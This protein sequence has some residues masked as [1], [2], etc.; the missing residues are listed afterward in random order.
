MPSEHPL[1]SNRVEIEHWA[2]LDPVEAERL[3]QVWTPYPIARFM[4]AWL[5]PI[6]GTILDPAVG[7]GVFLRALCDPVRPTTAQKLVGADLDEAMVESVR[8]FA[9][10]LPTPI[11]T[12]VGD[13]LEACRQGP[14]DGLI[15]N[16]PYIRHHDVPDEERLLAELDAETGLRF[17][18]LMNLYGIFVLRSALALAP[19]G[20]AAILVPSEWLNANFGR[21]L[22]RFLLL[23]GLLRGIVAFHFSSQ[24]FSGAMTTAGVLLLA[25]EPDEVPPPIAFLQV[26]SVDEL[27]ALE[28]AVA[29]A[30]SALSF[31]RLYEPSKLDP[32]AKWR[33]LFTSEEAAPTGFVRLGEFAR[34]TRGIAT[35]HNAFFLRRGSELDAAGVDRK[36]FT[37]CIGRSE[38]VP[39]GAFTSEDLSW[40]EGQ[41]LPIWLLSATPD[42]VASD[43]T[44]VAF[45][46]SPSGHKARES[47]LTQHR[48][49]WY[50]MES[51]PVAPIWIG[52]FSRGAVK[53]VRNQTEALTLACYHIVRPRQPEF[54]DL[55]SA[56]LRTDRFVRE[57]A[58]QRREYGSGLIKVEPK[59][60]ENVLIPDLRTFSKERRQ[61]ILRAEKRAE[62]LDAREQAAAHTQLEALFDS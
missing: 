62:S 57:L 21:A 46:D 16:P 59:D 30:E 51:R 25:N 61:A 4:A 17:S 6:T 3:G 10:A 52:T 32:D 7:S 29:Q 44:L 42:D 9:P 31:G 58:R 22:K 14:Y 1:F 37:P 12:L 49:V 41:D 45:L 39:A 48:K 34:A 53:V 5:H 24:V 15:L 55:I 11:E 23:R 56:Y 36:Y 2:G 40:L 20:R 60:L 54:A 35:G 18:R 33:T 50:V 47:Y 26:E 19:G 27:A 13:G 43:P 8:A 38:Y 28:P